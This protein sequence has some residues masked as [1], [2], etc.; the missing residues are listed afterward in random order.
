LGLLRARHPWAEPRRASSPRASAGRR[1]LSW[2]RRPACE[3][4]PRTG[5]PR[6]PSW[7]PAARRDLV[8][9]VG[10]AHL[11]HCTSRGCPSSIAAYGRDAGSLSNVSPSCSDKPQSS[12]IR[13]V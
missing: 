11:V 9:G 6:T 7:S 4:R 10:V 13:I 3:L 2:E 5:R 8:V 1:S 12:I